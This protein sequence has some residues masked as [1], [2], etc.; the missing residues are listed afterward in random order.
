MRVDSIEGA[1]IAIM[2]SRH[3]SESRAHH[4]K[5]IGTHCGMA[6]IHYNSVL[7][8]N[9]NRSGDFAPFRKRRTRSR[10]KQETS[11]VLRALFDAVDTDRY[12][13]TCKSKR[14]QRSGVQLYDT[15]ERVL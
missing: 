10:A 6:K 1:A 13:W 14:L 8:Y 2:A 4:S 12:I 15:M 3:R 9:R 7:A 11:E 5:R